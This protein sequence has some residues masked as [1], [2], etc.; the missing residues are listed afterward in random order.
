MTRWTALGDW[1]GTRLRLWQR[2]AEGITARAD[3]R[4]VL[5][6]DRAPLCELRDCLAAWIAQAGN[7]E[8]IVLC[9][10]AGSEL[11]L[12]SIAHADCPLDATEWAA[13]AATLTVDGLAIRIAAGCVGRQP[14]NGQED[15]MRG[16]ETQIFGA[17]RLRPELAEGARAFVLPGTHSKWVTT[18]M[19]AITGLR[20]FMSGE[21]FDLLQASSLF[22]RAGEP[23]DEG[24]HEGFAAGLA[25]ARQGVS[26]AGG[27]FHT[28]VAQLREQRSRGWA[29]GY[30]SGLIIGSEVGEMAPLLPPGGVTI[31]GGAQLAARYQRALDGCG[32]AAMALDGDDCALAGLEVLDEFA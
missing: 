26:L 3:G 24:T 20:S 29:A 5:A 25:E 27:L 17:L 1:G 11:G 12:R 15:V 31:I 6:L 18:S 19:G 14:G 21:L 23:S 22:T 9:G 16:E 8:R 4:G 2:Q 10:M 28:R 7:P 32:V 13:H 30:L